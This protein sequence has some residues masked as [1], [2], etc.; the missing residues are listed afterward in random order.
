[1]KNFLYLLATDQSE[2]LLASIF[3]V[4]LKALSYIYWA[5][6]GLRNI[7]YKMG[8]LKA[9]RLNK[10]VISVGNMTLG[11][12]GKT[13]LVQYIVNVL[14][15]KDL[16][17][18]V[19]I[20]GY[21]GSD[22]SVS[23]E[24]VM[25]QEKFPDVPILIG[26]NR[27]KNAHDYLLNHFVDAFVLDDGFQHLK[28]A[29]DLEIVVINA[30]NPFGNGSLIPRGILREPL[31]SLLRA[32]IIVL[33]KADLVQGDLSSLKKQIRDLNPKAVITKAR[34]APT[35]LFNLSKQREVPVDILNDKHI[36]VLCSIG[37]PDS[38]EKTLS[39]LGARI[40]IRFYFMD[41]YSYRQQDIQ[42][43]IERCRQE[44]ISTVLTTEKDSVKLKHY[45]GAFKGGISLLALK[46]RIVLNE[47]REDCLERI[48]SVI[49]R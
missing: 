18:A 47:G 20:R 3:K 39:N 10:P 31:S 6:V 36:C 28:M 41:H 27:L 43:L 1:M 2:G 46:M 45:L 34:H 17:P 29:R 21:M 9:H 38:F 48:H 22:S 37:D 30:T 8:I 42:T 26:K 33:S 13:P 4:L 40:K 11:G 5:I 35:T 14:K 23:D 32:D 49:H 19:L 24:G 15:D 12:V 25:L 16:R 44:C 7:L